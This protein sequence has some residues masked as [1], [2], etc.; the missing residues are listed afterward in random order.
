MYPLAPI[1]LFTFNRPWHT[2]QTLNALIQNVLANE[3]ILYV[4]ADGPKENASPETLKNIAEVRALV[5]SK[6]WCKEVVLVASDTNIGCRDSIIRGISEVLQKH[7]QVIIMEDDIITSPQFLTYMNLSLNYYKDRMAVFSIS[8]HSHSPEKYKIPQDYTYDVYVSP[9]LFNWGWGTWANRWNQ[10]NWSLDYY[11]EFAK[12]K[13]EVEAFNRC[14]DDLFKMLKEEKIGESDAWDIQ[15]TFAHFRN[16]AVSI[17]PC[18]PYTRNIGLDGSGTHCNM[19]DKAELSNTDSAKSYSYQLN[20][21]KTP[22][23]ID[24]LYEDKRI[25]NSIYS[26]FYPQKRPVWQ[27]AINRLSRMLGRENVFVIK[28]KIY[29]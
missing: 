2:E 9:R 23:L 21:N 4:Y 15:F 19:G 7:E 11:N 18:I 26:A 5:L 24:I 25:I 22:K 6:Q 14:G 27:K 12:S 17:V 10:T 8:G 28:K 16:H 1:V 20:T 29:N 13:Y 3:S